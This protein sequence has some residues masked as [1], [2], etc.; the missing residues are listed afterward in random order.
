MSFTKTNGAGSLPRRLSTDFFGSDEL[1]IDGLGAALVGFD[2]EADALAFVE[3]AKSGGLNG[4]HVDE[5]VLAAAFR[6]DEPET[7]RGVEELNL[8]NGHDGFL[9]KALNSAANTMFET[10]VE[11]AP[12]FQEKRRRRHSKP[13]LP[14][15][16]VAW[17]RLK[18]VTVACAASTT[19][20]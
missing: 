4:G 3:A 20:I 2:V 10:V 7:L 18:L 15:G 9:L 11:V 13:S 12:I 16:V 1:Q 5:H 14:Q 6:R 8:T 17:A 19:P